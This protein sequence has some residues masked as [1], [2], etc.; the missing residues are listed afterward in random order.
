MY[1]GIVPYVLPC[2]QASALP[3]SL[4]RC[5][6]RIRGIQRGAEPLAGIRGGCRLLGPTPLNAEPPK[7]SPEMGCG[8][9]C[10]GIL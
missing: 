3:E 9:S 4:L 6:P 10:G 8:H 7:T 2:L 5:L 1:V